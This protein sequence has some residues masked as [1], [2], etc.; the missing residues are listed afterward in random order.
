MLAADVATPTAVVA[1]L[2]VV[3]EAILSV[4]TPKV[5]VG[6]SAL[7]AKKAKALKES[8]LVTFD[9]SAVC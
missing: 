5:V 7:V 1:A 6:A 3:A 2:A 8:A 9:E 4:P